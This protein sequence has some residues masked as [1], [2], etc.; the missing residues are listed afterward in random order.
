MIMG[1]RKIKFYGLSW[2]IALHFR[3]LDEAKE[4]ISLEGFAVKNILA[5]SSMVIRIED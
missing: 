4:F 2:V 1:K 5:K 3:S